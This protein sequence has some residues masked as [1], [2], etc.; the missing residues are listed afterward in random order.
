MLSPL[1]NLSNL[2]YLSLRRE[3]F[4]FLLENKAGEEGISVRQSG[5]LSRAIL[6]NKQMKNDQTSDE[7]EAEERL[8]QEKKAKQEKIWNKAIADADTDLEKLKKLY[9]SMGGNKGFLVDPIRYPTSLGNG[10]N[11]LP[12]IR[13]KPYTY[14]WRGQLE[15]GASGHSI[16]LPMTNSITQNTNPNWSQEE[17]FISRL[18]PNVADGGGLGALAANIATTAGVRVGGAAVSGLTTALGMPDVTKASLRAFGRSYNP[19][20]ERFFDGV[21]F[22]VYSFEHK[23][24]PRDPKESLEVSRLIKRF[25]FYSL[26][27]IVGTRVFMTYPSVWRIGFFDQKCNRN[28]FLP[29]L[30]DCVITLVGVV[31]GG[32]GSWADLANG[33]PIE[34]TLS[35]QVTET[36]IPTKNRMEREEKFKSTPEDQMRGNFTHL[37]KVGEQIVPEG[38]T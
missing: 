3:N 15:N 11:P 6:P 22:R 28:E 14:N 4:D 26:P 2:V 23:F 29:V 5:S 18:T 35:L 24:M 38:I 16:Y 37:N 13:Y 1:L 30:E 31:F 33:S 32:G 12:F 19:F 9:K 36:T 10:E 27:N 17:D 21:S 34:T 7:K 25:Q 8:L 20:H